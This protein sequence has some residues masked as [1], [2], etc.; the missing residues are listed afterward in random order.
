MVCGRVK[1]DRPAHP[2]HVVAAHFGLF[3]AA[4][5]GILQSAAK[6]AG[7]QTA[8]EKSGRGGEQEMDFDD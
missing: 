7:V 5:A 8:I 3:T 4:H 6:V 1:H 2:T